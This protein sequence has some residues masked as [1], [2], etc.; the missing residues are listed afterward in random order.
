MKKGRGFFT[1][2]AVFTASVFFGVGANIS[3][4]KPIELT[5]TNFFPPT[6]VQSQLP[7]SWCKEVEKRTNGQ[8]K[9]T[10]YPGGTLSKA[11][12]IFTDIL[13]GIADMGTSVMGYTPGI[14]K[15][16]EA[17]DLPLGYPSAVIATRIINDFYHHFKP[18]SLDRVKVLYFHAHGPGILHSKTPVRKLE[19]LRGMK[20][21]STG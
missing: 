8:V 4:A 10:Y 9:I 7:E 1:L 5:Y 18:K 17:I 19:D 21:R 2:I 12:K 11:D 6:H 13:D 16:M 15:E 20:I 14:F 3:S